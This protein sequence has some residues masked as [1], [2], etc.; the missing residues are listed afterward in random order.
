MYVCWYLLV[1]LLTC[2][3]VYTCMCTHICMHM[4]VWMCTC[5]YMHIYVYM[6]IVSLSFSLYIH[7]LTHTPACIYICRYTVM[8]ICV[9]TH[10]HTQL[11]IYIVFILLFVYKDMHARTCWAS[12]QLLSTKFPWHGTGQSRAIMEMLVQCLRVALCVC[13][14]VFRELINIKVGTKIG[15][16]LII[17][18]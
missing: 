6:Y 13:F 15:N 11:F 16:E 18:N 1:C 8:C 10:A 7:T 2:S 9:G 3:C 17:G 12:A 14:C 4:H 5:I